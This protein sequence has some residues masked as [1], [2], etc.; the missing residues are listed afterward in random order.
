MSCNVCI[1]M[2]FTW[3][4][5]RR[6]PHRLA[7]C[8]AAAECLVRPAGTATGRSKLPL[9]LWLLHKLYHVCCG[10][11][12]WALV[13]PR[14]PCLAR[15]RRGTGR[16][17]TAGRPVMASATC[18]HASCHSSAGQTD[19]AGRCATWHWVSRARLGCACI[20]PWMYYRF[21]QDCR[22]HRHM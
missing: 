14:L 17:P 10:R 9:L 3:V 18:V 21:V 12:I 5:F 16:L 6:Q 19:R 13:E 22:V 2:C 4:I 15:L 7:A 11:A 8:N 20:C 1:S